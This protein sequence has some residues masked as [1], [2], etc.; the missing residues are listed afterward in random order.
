LQAQWPDT[1][2]NHVI[3]IGAGMAGCSTAWSL[4]QRGCR[5]TVLESGNDIACGASGNR[6]A[7]L[8]CRL[9]NAVN[10]A[11]QFN[12]QA[13]LHSSRHFSEM[14]VKHPD[15]HWQRCGVLNLDTAF[16]SRR[17]KCPEVR[18]DFY[19]PAVVRRIAQEEASE[20]AGVTLDGGGNYIALGGW[21]RPAE[22][23]R[24]WL[25][26]PLVSVRCAVHADTLIRNA[27]HWAVLGVNGEILG[28]ADA[29]VIANST[30]A[31]R[32][33]QTRDLPLIPLRG[34][35]SYVQAG[36]QSAALRT[37]VC[38]RSYI[39]PPHSGEHSTGA[40]YSKDVS[41]LS[42]SAKD[43]ADNVEGIAGHLPAGALPLE[44]VSG[45]RV[46]VRAGTGDRMPMVGPAVDMEALQTLYRGLPQRE[47]KSPQVMTPCHEGLYVNVGH[48]SHG[49]SNA[50]LAGEYLASL[51]F[52]EPL[53]VQR[54]VIE[55][56]HP[57]RFVLRML[58]REP[59]H[60]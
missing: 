9:N 25:Q 12:L 24:A 14:Q 55:C 54:D 19:S 1:V 35:V 20:L 36:A 7:V 22:L 6:Q 10:A 58:R 60:G 47:R 52:K 33:A 48:G 16:Q 29:I 17:E 46:S 27:E 42:L 44:A 21:L 31:T 39:S 43:G 5:V 57:A 8:Q 40:T 37:V 18:L 45:G 15:I 41:N 38:G 53:P 49:L 4:A 2:P 11:W 3:V 13:F 26:H 30:A 56:L 32:F 50:P 23:C 34:Q 51:L 28:K 59:A